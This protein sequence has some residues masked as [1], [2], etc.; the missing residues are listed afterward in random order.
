MRS[1][2]ATDKEQGSIGGC[3]RGDDPG[4]CRVGALDAGYRWQPVAVGRCDRCGSE[5]YFKD[6]P[7]DNRRQSLGKML[8]Y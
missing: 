1:G 4:G 7:V 2:L 3:Q 6:F 8:V 5:D